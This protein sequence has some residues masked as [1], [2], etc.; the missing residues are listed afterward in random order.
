MERM[1]QGAGGPGGRGPGGGPGGAGSGPGNRPAPPG[2]RSPE[3]RDERRRQF[4]DSGT[5]AGRAE[6]TQ[7][8]RDLN[9][10]RAQLGL[11]AGGRGFGPPR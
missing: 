4:L 10:R 2:G 7:F 3:A 9:A 1:R 5:P 11:P 6:F 8:M